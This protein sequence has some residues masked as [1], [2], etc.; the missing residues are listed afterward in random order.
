[1]SHRGADELSNAIDRWLSRDDIGTGK[2]L[3]EIID[4][5]AEALPAVTDSQARERVRRR[6]VG[7]RP[8]P[9]SAQEILLERAFA[10]VD[11]LQHR[12]RE[13]EY[14]PFTA[15]A[16]AALV[17]VGAFGLAIWLRHRGIDEGI[18]SD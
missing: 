4:S 10:E 13:E 15:V 9:R 16:T 8:R 11:R 3:A 2:G 12:I 6:L 5:L 7:V 17:V 14:V 18:S 1:M